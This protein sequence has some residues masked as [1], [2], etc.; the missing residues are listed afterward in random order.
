VGINNPQP[1]TI[2]AALDAFYE[3]EAAMDG[4]RERAEI[5]EET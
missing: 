1:A 2:Q 5:K 3:F 4:I